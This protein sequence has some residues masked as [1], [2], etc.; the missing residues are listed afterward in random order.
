MRLCR[1]AGSFAGCPKMSSSQRLY[2]AVEG[3]CFLHRCILCC[4]HD[5]GNSQSDRFLTD[6]LEKRREGMNKE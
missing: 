3:E 2:Q 5:L 6:I 4:P 1:T